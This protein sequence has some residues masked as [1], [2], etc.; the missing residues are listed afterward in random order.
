MRIAFAQVLRDADE[1]VREFRQLHGQMTL[2]GL[3]EAP[4]RIEVELHGWGPAD[5]AIPGYRRIR[6]SLRGETEGAG[7]EKDGVLPSSH[8]ARG[9]SVVVRE[10][11]LHLRDIPGMAEALAAGREELRQ[12]VDPQ[13]IPLI[14]RGLPAQ[15]GIRIVSAWACVPARS[16]SGMI[17][18]VGCYVRAMR[19]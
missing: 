9:D 4:K 15:S 8:L 13:L 12:E 1:L 19:T 16:L 2:A 3:V 5:G 10:G 14:A 11:L 17:E 18:A 6:A 7:G